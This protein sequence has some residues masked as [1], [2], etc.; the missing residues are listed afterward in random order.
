MR[1]H[2]VFV[3]FLCSFALAALFLTSAAA[4]AAGN[5]AARVDGSFTDAAGEGAF[6]G[7]LTLSSFELRGEQLVAHAT[8]DGNFTDG[9]GKRLGELE[10][11]ELTLPVDRASVAASCEKATLTLRLDDVEGG[12]VRAHLQ[13]VEVEIGA[14]AAPDHKLDVPL[15]DLGKV[16]GGSGGLGA[17]A[18]GLDRV[19]A[20][21]E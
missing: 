14:G 20:A 6:E 16:V 17:V 9:A 4:R 12:G 21:L 5:L 2:R 19:L 10:D 1:F 13:P 15:C 11:R 8:L 3:S 18:Q 7:T